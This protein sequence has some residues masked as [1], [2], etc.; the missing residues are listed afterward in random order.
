M[1]ACI[2]HLF[3]QEAPLPHLL[4]RGQASFSSSHWLPSPL[5]VLSSWPCTSTSS[6]HTVKTC[7][8]T[9]AAARRGVDFFKDRSPGSSSYFVLGRVARIGPHGSVDAWEAAIEEC[10][11]G[12][13][14]RVAVARQTTSSPSDRSSDSAISRVLDTELK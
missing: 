11:F 2:D 8:P 12:C 6:P 13:G 14:E 1:A 7:A 9:N 10:T 5:W 4:R 3:C